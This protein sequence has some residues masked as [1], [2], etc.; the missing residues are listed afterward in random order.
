MEKAAKK[1]STLLKDAVALF[2]I[3]LISGLALAYV[4]EI[5][6]EPIAAQQKEKKV[7]AYTVLFADA[8]DFPIDEEL[9]ALTAEY[10]LE[11]LNPSFN[12]AAID[13][14]NKAIDANGNMLGYVVVVTTKEGYKPPMTLAIGY[15][16]EHKLTGLEYIV[17]NENKN[18]DKIKTEYR[19]QYIG[20][21]AELFTFSGTEG[22]QIDAVSGSTVSSTAILNAVNAGIGF[23]NEYSDELGGG[24]VENE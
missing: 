23:L 22:T 9:S 21:T 12:K 15:T 20:A 2:L 14:I 17:F 13:E 24:A 4:F 7:K 19:N 11:S 10:D 5:T 18:I 16:K 6:K 3:T 1:K 8:K